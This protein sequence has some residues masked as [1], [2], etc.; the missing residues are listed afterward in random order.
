[1]AA[2]YL[3]L[4]D[5]ALKAIALYGNADAR[6]EIKRYLNYA[7]R[8]IWE[9]YPWPFRRV[10]A[11]VNTVAPYTTGTATFT[12]GS[13]TVAG[14]GT[15][16]TAAMVGRKIAKSYNDPWYTITAR[17]GNTALTLDR[18]YLEDTAAGTTYV[19]YDDVLT[20]ASTADSLM[21]YEVTL[22]D[23]GNDLPLSWMTNADFFNVGVL[24]GSAGVPTIYRIYEESSA[25]MQIQ[26]HPVPD[27][28]YALRYHYLKNYVE[29]SASSD[30]TGMP[31][32][33]D[34]LVVVGAL[35]D[36][37]RFNGE[38]EKA[39]IEEQRFERLLKKAWERD[40]S[41]R[42]KS[43]IRRPFDSPIGDTKKTGGFRVDYP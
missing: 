28:V 12:E 1:M 35:R 3:N 4:Q 33:L 40:E 27:D 23:N 30:T 13:A 9:E 38:Y 41:L 21:Q 20:L 31:A 8:E 34:N 37:F 32:R 11:F 29:M 24:P 39:T 22:F 36:G 2:S 14:F 7:A 10:A 43:V 19:L 25:V 15:S 17:G 6:V 26:V 18:A 16:W 5:Q 42:P